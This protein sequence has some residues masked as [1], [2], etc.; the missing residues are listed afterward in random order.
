MRPKNTIPCQHGIVIG[1]KRRCYKCFSAREKPE[2]KERRLARNLERMNEWKKEEANL[3]KWR[4]SNK[5]SARRRRAERGDEFRGKVRK[6]AGLPDPTR[7][8]PL[9]CEICGGPPRGKHKRLVLEHCHLTGIFRG[10]VCDI[11]NR[12]IGMLGDLPSSVENAARYMK[13]A[14]AT[15]Q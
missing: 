12:A 3:A 13:R 7:P 4:E 9:L 8:E 1:K 5:L 15:A 10:W 14:Y 2:V 6:R 11:C